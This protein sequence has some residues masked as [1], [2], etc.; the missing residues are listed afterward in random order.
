MV[1][2]FVSDEPRPERAASNVA[3]HP[4]RAGPAKTKP[5]AETDFP[6]K[7]SC[8]TIRTQSSMPWARIAHRFLV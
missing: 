6:Q 5:R 7:V 2:A 4:G 1:S 8:L 3:S